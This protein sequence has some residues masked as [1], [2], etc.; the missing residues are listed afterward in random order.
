MFLDYRR[1]PTLPLRM[2]IFVIAMLVARRLEICV[3]DWRRATAMTVPTP[4]AFL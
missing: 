1:L 2:A 4:V 3:F